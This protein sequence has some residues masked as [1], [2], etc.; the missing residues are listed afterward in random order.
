MA[1]RH[2]GIMSLSS[3]TQGQDAGRIKEVN[4][5]VVKLP[6]EMPAEIA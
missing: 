3:S 4:P 1:L 6:D 2:S 5:I